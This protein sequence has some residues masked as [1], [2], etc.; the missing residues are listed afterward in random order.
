MVPLVVLKYMLPFGYAMLIANK[1][2]SRDN[3]DHHQP[4]DKQEEVKLLWKL[5]LKAN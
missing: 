5:Y 4:G 3:L 2:Y 1:L